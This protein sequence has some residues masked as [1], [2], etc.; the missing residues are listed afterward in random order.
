[1][2]GIHIALFILCRSPKADSGGPGN[3][4][5]RWVVL[6]ITGALS[7]QITLADP[8]QLGARGLP[9]STWGGTNR[10]QSAKTTCREKT[11]G[12]KVALFVGEKFQGG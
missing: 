6:S 10:C 8:H 11:L 4:A 12:P 5:T 1:M 2:F 7:L 3:S 9:Y